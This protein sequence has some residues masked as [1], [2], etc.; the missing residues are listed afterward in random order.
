MKNLIDE[1]IAQADRSMDL[2]EEFTTDLLEI[3]MESL[4]EFESWLSGKGR[5]QFQNS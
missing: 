5:K 3:E 4:E 1:I 2:A